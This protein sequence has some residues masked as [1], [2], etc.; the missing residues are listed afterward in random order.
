MLVGKPLKSAENDEH[1]LTRFAALA[2][3]SSDALSS[4]AYGTEQIVVVLVA[5]SAAAIWYSLPIA[6]FVIILLISLTLSY[7]QIIHAYPHGGGAYVVSSE[8]L[9]KNAGLISGGS[10]L[11]DYMLTV[12]VSVSAGAEAITSAVPALYGHQVAISVTIVLLLM[13][14]NLRGLRESAS[15]LLFPVYTFILVISLLIVVGL[16][17]IVTGAVPLQATALPGAAVPGVSIALILRAFSSGSSSLTGVEAISN[18]VPFFKK[19]RAKNAAATLTMMALILG[20]FFVGITFINYWYGIVPEKEVTVLSQIGK[21]VFGHGILYYVLQFATALILA[22]A[23]NT[24][25]SAF[26]VLAYNLAKDKFMPHMYQDRGDRLGYS[27]GIITLALG[28]IVLLFIFHGS[29]ERLIPLY[30]IG[31]FIPFALSQTGMV[32]KWKKEGKRWLSKS[33]ANITGA[34]ISYAI[35]A[36][37]F[38]YRLGD[39]WPFFII[40]PIVM[41]I[42]YKI[43]DHYKKVAEQLRLENDAKLHDYDGNTVLVLVGN[44]TRVNIGALNYA[45][46]I[47]DY[48]VAMHVSLDEDVEKEKEIEAEFKKHFPDVR[49]SIVHSSYRSIENPIIRYVDIVSKNAAKQNYTTTVLIPQFVPNR[50]WQNILHNQTSLR[51]RLRLSWRENIVVST[52]SYHLKK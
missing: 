48:V 13:M 25:F 4:I 9:G 15:F 19:P 23:A 26:P 35:I 34:F 27:N 33:I 3:L 32:V 39:I 42:F 36:I 14:L 46:S 18:A 40:M 12:A 31:V 21:A 2:L 44:V 16:Y 50:R 37:L 30:S 8:N 5:L 1:K 49:F 38:V 10:L 28:S 6:A 43:H 41:F 17:N 20:F 22:V 51:L 47:G 29:T 45:R 52:Y 24:G 7:R 11:I